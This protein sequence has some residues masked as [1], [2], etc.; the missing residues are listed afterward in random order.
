MTTPCP[1]H[2]E[3]LELLDGEV[4]ENRARELRE[5]L[6]A[7]PA[8]GEEWRAQEALIARLAAPVPGAPSEAAV[9]A[10]MRRISAEPSV[11]HQRSRRLLPVGALALAAAAGLAIVTL[12]RPPSPD[13]LARGGKPA[14]WAKKVGVEIWS[15]GS[16]PRPLAAGMAV[17]PATAYVARYRNLTGAPAY[18]LAFGVDAAGVVHWL[19]PA[20]LDPGTDPPSLALQPGTSVPLLESV[21]LEDV[22]P[23]PLDMVTILSPAPLSVSRVERL[24]PAERE[25]AALRARFPGARVDR[26]TVRVVAPPRVP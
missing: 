15:I 11:P 26:V 23:G 14:S 5:H 22:A 1:G 10:V 24:Q 18:L 6:A 8:C 2:D 3:L 17:S 25:P 16:P 4:T 21:V 20:F 12:V 7:C 9:Q 13:F 19:Y